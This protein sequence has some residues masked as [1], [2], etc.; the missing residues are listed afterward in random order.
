MP[1]RH[2]P[3]F[4]ISATPSLSL[5]PDQKQKRNKYQ[6]INWIIML[7]QNHL[8]LF[9]FILSDLGVLISHHYVEPDGTTWALSDNV[10]GQQLSH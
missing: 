9:V 8:F 7:L 2:P 5:W 4:H 6:N 10:Q 1:L 3:P